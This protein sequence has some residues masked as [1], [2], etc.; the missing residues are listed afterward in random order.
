MVGIRRGDLVHAG[1]AKAGRDLAQ[2]CVDA[3]Q[4]LRAVLAAAIADVVV[5]GEQPT[6]TQGPRHLGE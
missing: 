3:R 4:P 6:G 2:Q 5:D 1:D